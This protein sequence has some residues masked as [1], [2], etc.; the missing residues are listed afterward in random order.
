MSLTLQSEK[1]SWI[2]I[3]FALIVHCNVPLEGM[4]PLR[5]PLHPWD[6]NC[7]TNLQSDFKQP[8]RIG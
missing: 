3:W 8:F 4:V 6:K 2:A 7:F 1:E 5:I